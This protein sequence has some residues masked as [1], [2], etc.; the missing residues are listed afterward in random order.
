MAENNENYVVNE[1]AKEEAPAEVSTEY[2]PEVKAGPSTGFVVKVVAVVGAA[3][4]GI[5][6]GVR[7]FLDWRKKR[8]E[9]KA[10]EKA[11]QKDG[12]VII[13]AIDDIPDDIPEK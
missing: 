10:N 13:D 6:A 1:V 9:R 5:Y 12:E 8:K 3:G 11:V 4:Y 2:T 7:D